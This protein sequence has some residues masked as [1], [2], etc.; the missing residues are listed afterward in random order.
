MFADLIGKPLRRAAPAARRR[1]QGRAG[2]RTARVRTVWSRSSGG[3]RARRSRSSSPCP[4]R[5]TTRAGSPG[6]TPTTPAAL[7]ASIIAVFATFAVALRRHRSEARIMYLARYDALT[8]LANRRQLGEHLD[9]LFALPQR[10]RAYRAAYHRSR[11][12]QVHQR[13]LWPSVRRHAAQARRRPPARARA[14][15]GPRGAPRRRRIRDRPVAAVRPARGAGA[16]P[17]HLPGTGGAL[18]IG[19]AKVVIGATRRHRLG[20]GRRQ[21][22][23]RAPEGGGSRALRRQV[24]RQGRL[25]L[26]RREHDAR[27]A[28]SAPTSRTACDRRSTRRSS[29]S[30]IS[31]SSRL[32]EQKTIGYEALI[33]WI[34]PEHGMVSAARISF[35]WPRRPG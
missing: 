6:D 31:R 29:G 10:E 3:S 17:A 24:G 12:V 16:R 2:R 5:R 15:L 34:R 18:R 8:N 23:E 35:R 11:P 32:E 33:R 22:G 20:D 7:A 25:P 13:H 30:S 14:A 28:S 26:L 27:G 4:T 19:N 1:R 9:A 21:F